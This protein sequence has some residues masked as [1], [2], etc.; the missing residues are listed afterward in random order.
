MR[1]RSGAVHAPT[2][3]RRYNGKTYTSHLPRRSFRIGKQVQHET[4]GNLS[5]RPSPLIE[6][7][8]RSLAAA[9]FLVKLLRT[10]PL[11]AHGVRPQP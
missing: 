8:R 10:P 2:T 4:S 1:P 7:I 9:T 6:I 5:H 3:T 11:P